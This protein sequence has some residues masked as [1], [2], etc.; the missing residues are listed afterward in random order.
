MARWKAMLDVGRLKEF[1]VRWLLQVLNNDLAFAQA[2]HQSLANGSTISAFQEAIHQTMI[3]SEA[4]VILWFME[5]SSWEEV[6]QRRF[7]LWCIYNNCNVRRKKQR[8]RRNPDNMYL[9][10]I[11]CFQKW[12][13]QGKDTSVKCAVKLVTKSLIN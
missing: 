13:G 5:H 7:S 8:E 6:L 2:C 10:F 9:N 4:R 1:L 11:Q 3:E 12:I